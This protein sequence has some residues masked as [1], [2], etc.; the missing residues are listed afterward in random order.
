MPPPRPT[1]HDVASRAGVSKS[2][3]S[4]AMRGSPKVSESSR[5]AIMTAA[6]E[7]GYRPNAAARS[8]ADRRSRTIGVLILD[9]HNPVF[10]E[11]LDGAQAEIRRH[12]YSTML[13]SGGADPVR[14]QA[15]IEKLL[16]FC[17]EGL[18]L[19]SHR[20]SATALKEVA[21]EVPTVVVT[22][23]DITGPRI[24]TVSNDD[25]AGAGL[26]VDHLVSLGHTRITCLTGGENP[27]SRD[28]ER[29]YREAMA[30]HGL[31]DQVH[32][33]TGGLTDAEGY[34]A[35]EQA[36]TSAPTALFAANDLAAVGAV[37]ALQESGLRVPEDV[38]V[39]GYD[40]IAV[41][42]LRSVGLTSVAQPLAHM[43][44]LAARRLFERIDRPRA[45]T[46]H[47]T[48]EARLA[49]RGTTGPVRPGG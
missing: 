19:V 28:R 18:I 21:A 31:A 48:V 20:L 16:E 1:I 11:I 23:R 9:L 7:L 43:G 32:V 13:V 24:D 26:A 41:G 37:A 44:E 45:R 10:A 39:V 4:L 5:E 29:G 36:L 12:D 6:N 22:R 49:V 17:V 15:D 2:L 30:R 25:V 42:S 3:V 40:G 35:A 27:V 33:V 47:L 14:E 38:S 46:Q 34:V 8:L